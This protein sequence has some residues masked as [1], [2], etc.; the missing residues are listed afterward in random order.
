MLCNKASTDIKTITKPPPVTTYDG[1]CLFMCNKIILLYIINMILS[2]ISS[3]LI[4]C[5]L[6]RWH[7]FSVREKNNSSMTRP[8]KQHFDLSLLNNFI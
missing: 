4:P 3:G 1:Q 6:T 7:K 2:E 8:I 5:N